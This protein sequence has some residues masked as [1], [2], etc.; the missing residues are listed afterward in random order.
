MATLKELRDMMARIGVSPDTAEMII[1]EGR[2][3]FCG[4]KTYWTPPGSN[5]DPVRAEKIREAAKKLPTGV[6][7]VRF[8]VSDRYV[9]MVVK[10]RN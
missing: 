2:K 10:K 7:A 5:R 1:A 8:G 9:R 3:T 6:T 4:D